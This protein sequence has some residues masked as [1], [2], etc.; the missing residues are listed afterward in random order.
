MAKTSHFKHLSKI[1]PFPFL[2]SSFL[3][4]FIISLSIDETIFSQNF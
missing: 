1:K 2:F 3:E 4:R